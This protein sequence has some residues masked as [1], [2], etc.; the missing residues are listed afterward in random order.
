MNTPRD[1]DAR[2]GS[3]GALD[4][5]TAAGIVSQASA[6]A[7]RAFQTSSPIAAAGGAAV[8][9][10]GYGAAWWSMLGQQHPTGP[11]WWALIVLYGLIVVTAIAASLLFRRAA[12]GI[13][14]RA[15]RQATAAGVAIATAGVAAWIVEGALRSLGLSFAFVYGVYAPT[16]PLI[17]LTAAST[18]FAASRAKWPEYSLA[19]TIMLIAAVSTFFGPAGAWG[20]TGIG[21]AAALLVY[22]TVLTVRMRRVVPA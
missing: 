10:F 8:F 16:V 12:R 7:R 9:L 15:Q 13:G 19:L 1:T 6:H 21:C 20:L 14:G 18:G 2:N 4:P 11:S 3:D 22:A 5:G 17:V